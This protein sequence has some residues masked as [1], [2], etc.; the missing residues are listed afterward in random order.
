[1]R[2]SQPT[3]PTWSALLNSQHVSMWKEQP[4]GL[5][6]Y[7]S[8]IVKGKVRLRFNFSPRKH[9]RLSHYNQVLALQQC[10]LFLME[11][12]ISS[13]YRIDQNWGKGVYLTLSCNTE[14]SQPFCFLCLP[15]IIIYLH[16]GSYRWI[17]ELPNCISAPPL[18]V[19]YLN[20]LQ[21][22]RGEMRG[23]VGLQ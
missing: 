7:L 8:L 9:Q 13:F 16:Q 12:K 15:L 22:L 10:A 14:I 21:T 3:G 2:K 20:C 23:K 18:N 17:V 4:L 19:C 5:Q 6:Q 11:Q 1:M